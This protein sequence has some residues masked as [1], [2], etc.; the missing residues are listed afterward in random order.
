MMKRLLL[1]LIVAFA[2]IA[3]CNPP[4]GGNKVGAI[5]PATAVVTISATTTGVQTV[6]ATPVIAQADQ[7]TVRF[8]AQIVARDQATGNSYSA[9]AVSVWKRNGSTMTQSSPTVYSAE[10]DEIGLAPSARPNFAAS[11]TGIVFNVSGLSGLTIGFGGSVAT[12]SFTYTITAPTVVTYTGAK[13]TGFTSSN[14]LS[15]AG[16][17]C[18]SLATNHTIYIRYSH[19]APASGAGQFPMLWFCATA[20]A[21]NAA[22]AG[23]KGWLLTYATSSG[24]IQL[25]MLNGVTLTTYTIGAPVAGINDIVIWNDGTNVNSTMTGVQGSGA[26][27]GLLGPN[28][29]TSA[30]SPTYVAPDSGSQNQ[31]GYWNI[32]NSNL[33]TGGII[34]AGALSRKPVS[35]AE[36]TGWVQSATPTTT[37][38]RY[39]LPS[40][41]TGDGSCTLDWNE[42]R[43]YAGAQTYSASLG[44]SP[45][46]WT[47]NGTPT[48]TNVSEEY[49][50]GGTMTPVIVDA[51]STLVSGSR[52][53]SS[54]LARTVFT[55]P[56]GA[57][58]IGLAFYGT[59]TTTGTYNYDQNGLTYDGTFVAM[60]AT[61][62]S[63]GFNDSNVHLFWAETQVATATQTT[64]A[65]TTTSGDNISNPNGGP[66]YGGYY[67]GIQVS[68]G[69]PFTTTAPNK[70]LVAGLDSIVNGYYQVNPTS[71]GVGAR[72]RSN[73]PTSGGPGGVTVIGFGGYALQDEIAGAGIT[74]VS[75]GISA[76]A[77]LI[78]TATESVAAVGAGKQWFYDDECFNTYNRNTQTPTGWAAS[79][80]SLYDAIHADDANVKIVYSNCPQSHY[81]AIAGGSGAGSTLSAYNTAAA[82]IVTGRSSFVT[83]CDLT[84]AGITFSDFVHPDGTANGAQLWESTVRTCAGWQIGCRADSHEDQ[85]RI[86]GL[87]AL[88]GSLVV[89]G[90]AL[91]RRRRANDNDEAEEKLAA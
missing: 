79:K 30:A 50:T 22:T 75:G 67:A 37:A 43:D 24:N 35:N 56:V 88:L 14:Y 54:P 25:W 91:L 61:P 81:N 84:S 20:P 76:L 63:G 57:P 87:A 64:H 36:A 83:Y 17:T 18:P 49:L 7:T 34:A 71:T 70:R 86:P 59:D 51:P 90:G 31:L 60:P 52:I 72:M 29:V 48:H 89:I 8:T 23:D 15:A 80:G 38:S 69:Q 58:Q 19:D 12:S 33:Y 62:G 39:T 27:N 73:F 55:T 11:G 65:I 78:A 77:Q 1:W 41:F 68:G 85:L 32:A 6:A 16:T 47:V 26:Y 53:V 42:K 4:N 82:G 5:G 13:V 9:Q 44:S 74:G 3:A 10:I 28:A 21:G 2:A 66:V 45:I 40:S 46:T